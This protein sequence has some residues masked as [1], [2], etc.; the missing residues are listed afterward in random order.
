MFVMCYRHLVYSCY[1]FWL[2]YMVTSR[3]QAKLHEFL[4]I[5][6]LPTYTTYDGFIII[7]III[8]ARAI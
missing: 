3:Q 7:I 6:V 5:L 4:H 1:W 8:S 2:F